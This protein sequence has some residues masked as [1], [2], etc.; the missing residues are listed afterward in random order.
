MNLEAAEKVVKIVSERFPNVKAIAWR[1]DVSKESEVEAAVKK[2][3]GEFG[4]LDVMVTTLHDS[5]KRY[6]D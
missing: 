1:A 3:V 6:M 5:N 4:R 2:A